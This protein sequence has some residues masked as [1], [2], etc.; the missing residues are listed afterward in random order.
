MDITQTT[1]CSRNVPWNA[2]DLLQG[3]DPNLIPTWICKICAKAPSPQ[4]S[5]LFPC[6]ACSLVYYCS[7]QCQQKD[8]DHREYCSQLCNINDFHDLTQDWREESRPLIMAVYGHA[9]SQLIRKLLHLAFAY[10]VYPLYAK[11]LS[12]WFDVFCYSPRN[13]YVALGAV[14]SLMLCM[15]QDDECFAFITNYA[16]MQER[17]VTRVIR[18]QSCIK[19]LSDRFEKKLDDPLALPSVDEHTFDPLLLTALCII[20]LRIIAAHEARVHT[21]LVFADTDR[22]KMLGDCLAHVREWYLGDDGV[23][24]I[25]AEQ[26]QHVERYLHLIHTQN[27]TVLPALL[28]PTPLLAQSEPDD[29]FSGAPSEAW[30]TIS[31]L[32]NLFARIPGALRQVH[33]I[34]GT[35]IAYNTS[36]SDRD[37]P[38]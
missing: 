35:V 33:E 37:V 1:P 8:Q 15:N 2:I 3:G 10:N 11:A 19:W 27:A 21:L 17:P 30:Y 9:H 13:R 24:D 32:Q 6:S 28:N 7:P 16:R 34:V 5:H 23:A 25:V 20:K 4:G 29:V 14:I 26:H 18:K 36:V 22:G 12:A 31:N 38:W